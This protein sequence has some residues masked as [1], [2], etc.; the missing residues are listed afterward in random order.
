MD[1]DYYVDWTAT[2]KEH[3]R[4]NAARTKIGVLLYN[5]HHAQ[6]DLFVRL[7]KAMPQVH[8]KLFPLVRHDHVKSPLLEYRDTQAKG[9]IYAAPMSKLRPAEVGLASLHLRVICSLVWYSDVILLFGCQA[10]PALATAILAKVIGTKTLLV[11][12]GI[13][14]QQELRRW[15]II[16]AAK[17]LLI[18]LVDTVIAQTPPSLENL[19][20]V[21]HVPRK[22]IVYA[23]YEAGVLDWMGRLDEIGSD[24]N[25]IRSDLGVENDELLLLFVGWLIELKGC[26]LL[27]DAVAALNGEGMK[28]KVLLVGSSTDQAWVDG[29]SQRIEHHGLESVVV[30]VGRIQREDL[31]RYFLAADA[32]ILPSLRDMWPKVIAEA[33]CAGLPIVTTTAVG[34]AGYLVQDDINGYVIPPGDV[35]ELAEAIR[36]LAD[37]E[38]RHTFGVNSKR[39][40]QEYVNADRES[41]AFRAALRRM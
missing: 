35:T 19:Q 14:P 27:I 9:R 31:P 3:T 34:A 17:H 7:A 37:G 18:R 32:F 8:F 16:R 25:E 15:W 22:K 2:K 23:P 33:A 39:I 40:I 28:V 36:N 5:I 4:V 11:Y 41:E 26:H 20:E 10:F 38:R 6:T 1:K 12:Q 21:Y 29:L 30:K 13:A 24:R